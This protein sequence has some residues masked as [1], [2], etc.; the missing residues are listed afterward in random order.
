MP[1]FQP[2]LACPADRR[3]LGGMKPVVR[4]LSATGFAT[5]TYPVASEDHS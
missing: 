1:R 2:K 5:E 4:L 3:R